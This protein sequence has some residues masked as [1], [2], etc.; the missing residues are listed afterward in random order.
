MEEADFTFI[1]HNTAWYG[2]RYW[3][4]IPYPEGILTADLRRNGLKV[5]HID[6]N[7]I[8]LFDDYSRKLASMSEKEGDRFIEEDLERRVAE[9]NPKIV[10][11]SAMTI[12]YS[13]QIH[14]TAEI[15][16]RVNPKTVVVTGGIYPS[17][18]PEP[19][20]ADSN[21]DIIVSRE[22]E[23]RISPLVDAIKHGLPLDRIRGI[24]YRS[25]GGWV[26]TTK[27]DKIM[28]LDSL[29]WPDYSDYDMKHL[30]HWTQKYTQNFQ[31]RHPPHS[32]VMTS[33]GC[34]YHCNYCAAG[35]DM[36]PLG[37]DGTVRK[38]SPENVVAE[39]E[40]LNKRY[41]IKEVVFVDDS[42]LIPFPKSI[43]M[44]NL[45]AKKKEEGFDFHW[46]SNNLDI[47]HLRPDV[48]KAMKASG[49]YQITFSLESLSPNSMKRMNRRYDIG[50][51]KE[52][53]RSMREFDFDEICANFII[54]YPGDTM[55]DI[56]ENMNGADELINKE[57]LL[58]YALFS[59]ATPL[60]GTQLLED[61]LKGGYLPED[62]DSQKFYGFGRG[63]ITTEEFTPEILMNVRALEWDR[64]NFKTQS[65]REKVAK[66][67]GITMK[68][69]YAWRKDTRESAGVEVKTA[70]RADVSLPTGDIRDGDIKFEFNG[71]PVKES[72]KSRCSDNHHGQVVLS[73]G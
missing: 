34:P 62:F 28:N 55:D 51:A 10:G 27:E 33:R 17:L 23:Q 43:A 67:C 2:K 37:W 50:K 71:A 54:G 41:G 25:N 49:C 60:P 30:T 72:G 38:R 36:N 35:K 46:K 6:H 9:L 40:D 44:F 63:L 13:K 1:I 14:K 19:V 65:Q 58:D 45:L 22:A 32:V 42:L 3:N 31:F 15:V 47:R 11:I 56:W 53:M 7:V 29:P 57:G 68:E 24:S 70:D 16:K 64:M 26:H 48:L 73:C 39:I 52:Y 18:S 12:E 21:F 5:N 66:M 61:A 20:Y 8:N 69:L 4:H 59:I